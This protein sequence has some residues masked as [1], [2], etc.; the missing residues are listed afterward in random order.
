MV[1]MK[2]QALSNEKS[3]KAA[4]SEIR[5]IL[6]VLL[7]LALSPFVYYLVFDL[8]PKFS[9]QINDDIQGLDAASVPTVFNI[10]LHASNKRGSKTKC[11]R[12]GEAAVRYSGFTL[13]L[14]RTRT[15]CVGAKDTQDVPAVA[16][17]DGVG[18]PKQIGDRMME[19]QRAGLIELEVVVKL[20]AQEDSLGAEPT[21]MW[22]KVVTRGTEPSDAT[23][24]SVF[25]SKIW[26]S[27]FVPRW[28]LV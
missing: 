26:A 9:V 14:S 13:A 2:P 8:P 1:A 24:C 22:C 5:A 10:S 15:F 25:R 11:Y 6:Y 17:A 20:F 28:M 18:L 12:H 4:W 7:A 21:W 16:W 27:D 19:E 23:P 3:R